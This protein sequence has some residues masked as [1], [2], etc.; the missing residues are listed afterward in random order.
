M[1]RRF[2]TTCAVAFLFSGVFTF[3][4]VITDWN[5]TALNAIRS[6][7]TPPPL[8]ARNL[9]ILHSSIYDAVNGIHRTHKP[10]LVTAMGPSDASLDVAAAAAAHLVMVN[11]YPAVK[12]AADLQ[13]A[14]FLK[15]V[16]DSTQKTEGMQWGEAVAGIILDW[17]AN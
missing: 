1:L 13:Y 9:A 12:A 3:A 6:N 2:T 8:A 10:F 17:R 14:T 16:K 15:S 7:N 5:T 4:D 11:L